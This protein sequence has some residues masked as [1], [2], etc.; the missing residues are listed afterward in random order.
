MGADSMR[1]LLPETLDQ[2]LQMRASEPGALPIAG[3]TDLMVDWPLHFDLH[4]RPFL[5]LSGVEDL[6]SLVWGEGWLSIGAL[7][8]YWD[9]LGDVRAAAELSMLQAAARTVGAVQIQMR[10]TWAGNIANGSP[11]ADGVPVLMAYGAEVELACSDSTRRVPLNAYY[12]GYKQLEMRPDELITRVWVPRR[13]HQFEEFIKVGSRGAQAITKVGVALARSGKG[14]RVV[15][16]SMAPTVCRCPR[17]ETML[18][19]EVSIRSPT[20]L[21]D[22]IRA[23]VSPIDDIRS[24]ARYREQVMSRVVYHALRAECAWIH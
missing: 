8:T 17:L 13:S 19:E 12:H 6:R 1:V 4:Q 16:N 18:D 24:T 22:A 15:A 20:D 10:G 3:G 7:T 5:D 11:A 9:V 2:A 23:D 21:L 14:W